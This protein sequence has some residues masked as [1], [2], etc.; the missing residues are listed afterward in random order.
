MIFGNTWNVEVNYK[1]NAFP[2]DFIL[3]KHNDK[4]V[5]RTKILF[6]QIHTDSEFRYFLFRH[7]ILLLLL[8][9]SS[10]QLGETWKISLYYSICCLGLEWWNTL[11][12]STK[13]VVQQVPNWCQ[14]VKSLMKNIVIL[15][16]IHLDRPWFLSIIQ[17]KRAGWFHSRMA[18]LPILIAYTRGGDSVS[19]YLSLSVCHQTLPKRLTGL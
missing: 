9:A 16:T 19:S 6:F 14:G 17:T 18:R 2:R 12:V 7:T 4:Y 11:Y 8:L 13:A 5:T 10:P 1:A 15:E 3:N